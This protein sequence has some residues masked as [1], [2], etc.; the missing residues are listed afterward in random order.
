MSVNSPEKNETKQIS[1]V[2]IEDF[3]LTRVGLR[4]ALNANEDINVVGESENA[5]LG[6]E[7]IQKCKPNVVLMD[8]G[9]PDIDGI[10]ATNLIKKS[11]PNIR[12]LMYLLFIIIMK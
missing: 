12:I 1:V 4:C 2:I 11:N 5:I 6:L 8:I 7:L 3:K 10:Q 9:L